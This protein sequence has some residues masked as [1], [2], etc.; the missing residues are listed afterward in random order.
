M[1]NDLVT[2]AVL[3]PVTSRGL[4]M[5]KDCLHLLTRFARS[6]R[7]TTDADTHEGRF[8]FRVYLAI[9]HDDTLLIPSD[10]SNDSKAQSIFRA[11]GITDVVLLSMPASVPRGHVCELWRLLARRAHADACD[12][13][14]LMGDDVELED[15]GWMH[16]AH[17][18]FCALAQTRGVPA[19]FGCVAFTDTTFPGMPTFLIV[20][21]MHMQIFAGEVVPA[22]FKNQ[23]GEPFLFQLYRRWGCSRMITSRLR[24]EI[25]GK[26]DAH[27]QKLTAVEWTFETLDNATTRVEQW[28]K[29][30]APAVER[31]LTLDVVVPSYR[32]QLNLLEAILSLEASPTCSTMLILIIDDPHSPAIAELERRFGARADVRIRV[33]SVNLGASRSR[34]R[35]LYESAAEWVF[36]LDDDVQ[37]APDLLIAAERAIRAAPDAAGFVGSVRFPRAVSVRTTAIHLAGVLNFWDIADKWA[38]ADG[39]DDVPWG[40]TASLIVRRNIRDGVQFNPVFPKTGGGE[41]VDFCRKKRAAILAQGGRGF[42]PAPEVRAVHPWWNDGKPPFFRFYMWFVGDGALIKLHPDLSYRD[43]APSSAELFL[44]AGAGALVGAYAAVASRDPSVLLLSAR[45]AVCVFAA[46]I[47][48]DLYRHMW[49]DAARWK[50]LDTSVRGVE[51]VAAVAMSAVLRMYAEAGRT[52]GILQRWHFSALGRRFEWFAWRLG[53]APME[54]ERKNSVQRLIIALLLLAVLRSLSTTLL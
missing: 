2:Y 4:E 28:L 48:H 31:L 40:V 18:E 9:D 47:I 10:A 52:A 39:A 25:G 44:V 15:A 14:V 23:D 42:M 16:T 5:E 8:R 24:N 32:V 37:P 20:S 3:L 41:D 51:W 17:T 33:N 43:A 19:G 38:P 35:G 27:Y 6:L 26:H 36:F 7:L 46:N 13:F 49:R 53:K 1:P 29:A 12:Y 54:E 21:S 22:V 11:E 50:E 30:P 45:F 34:N